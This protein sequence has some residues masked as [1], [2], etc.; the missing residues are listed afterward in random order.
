MKRWVSAAVVGSIVG[1]SLLLGTAR[2]DTLL[3]VRK[4]AD[5]LDFVDP[6]SGLR[7]ASV[8]VGFAPHEV[9]VS[10]DGR[11]AVVSNYGTRE[12][13]GSTLS[14]VDLGQPRELRRIDL[15]PHTR[16]HG[17][18][19]YAPDRVAVTTE[20]SQHLLVVDPV[21][22][23]VVASIATGQQ[24]SH[25]VAVAPGG[26]RGYVAN[27]GSGS[28]TAATLDS[29]APVRSVPTGAG[30]EAI[31]IRPDGKEVWLAARAE[32]ALLRLDATSLE[33]IS[34][35]ALP[36]VPIRLAFTPD[37]STAFVTCAASAEVVAFDGATGRELGRRKI[38]LPLA[39]NA[40]SRPF[41]GLAAGSPL[42]VGLMVSPDGRSVFVAA[43]MADRV[44][45]LDATTLEVLRV[46][47]VAGEPDG[48]GITPMMPKAQCHACEN[49]GLR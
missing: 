43:T 40:A 7:L 37:G 9:S 33:R 26:R 29:A 2:A 35:V 10:P 42:P 47:E 27:I 19:W 14:V 31:A 46:I 48:L 6:G 5:A 22:G 25:M 12:R 13:P 34:R 23:T 4:S 17:V 30:T 3:V 21:A 1:L 20:G 24:V 49:T 18:A 44:V 39:A 41:A 45:Q 28:V 38:D 11:L 32:G 16:P 8:P 15:A 36:G